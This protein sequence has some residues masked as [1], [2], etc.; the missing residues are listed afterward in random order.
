VSRDRIVVSIGLLIVLVVGGVIQVFLG[1]VW[2]A[3]ACFII[4]ASGI[5]NLVRHRRRPGRV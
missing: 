3:L 2:S 4:A 1:A 5:Y